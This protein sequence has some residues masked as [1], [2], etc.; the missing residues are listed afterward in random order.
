MVGLD[1][2]LTIRLN[3]KHQ[4]IDV[5]SQS[6]KHPFY[7]DGFSFSQKIPDNLF[8]HGSGWPALVAGGNYAPADNF[9]GSIAT[10]SP[11]P[12]AEVWFGLWKVN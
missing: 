4:V 12:Q 9:T 10:D 6:T 3:R 1:E 7:T 5:N 2:K 8:I 11:Q